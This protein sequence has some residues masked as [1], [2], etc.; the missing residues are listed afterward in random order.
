MREPSGGFK[1]DNTSVLNG[2]KAGGGETNPDTLLPNQEWGRPEL[3]DE[4]WAKGRH[5]ELQRR[6]G[7][8]AW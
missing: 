5:T 7:G 6:W 2:D 8:W 3:R 1:R 4:Q